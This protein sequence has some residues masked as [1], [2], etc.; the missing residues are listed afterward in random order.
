MALLIIVLISFMVGCGCRFAAQT[1]RLTPDQVTPNIENRTDSNSFVDPTEPIPLQ[2]KPRR[3][4][5]DLKVRLDREH[6]VVYSIERILY[7]GR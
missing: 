1:S 3:K 2:R 6:V 7:S 4:F 5:S